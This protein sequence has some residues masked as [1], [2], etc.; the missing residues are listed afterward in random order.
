MHV[1]ALRRCPSGVR[2]YSA[3]CPRSWW[4]GVFLDDGRRFGSPLCLCRDEIFRA[5]VR[6]RLCPDSTKSLLRMLLCPGWES[7]GRVLRAWRWWRLKEGRQTEVIE[8][9]FGRRSAPAPAGLFLGVLECLQWWIETCVAPGPT[10]SQEVR[11]GSSQGSSTALGT[12]R[13]I[14]WRAARSSEAVTTIR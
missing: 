1:V 11:A 12:Y 13:R 4:P 8:P 2:Y 6:L 9:P 5:R 14:C 7:P 3:N 10:S